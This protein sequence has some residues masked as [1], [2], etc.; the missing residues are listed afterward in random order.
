M[1]NYEY[2]KIYKIT[3]KS[4]NLVYYGSTAL[5]YLSKRLGKHIGQ[6]KCYIKGKGNYCSSF[7]LLKQEDYNIQ[8]IKNFPCNNKT[9]LEKEESHF[10]KNNICVNKA[11]PGRTKQ[12]YAKEY[13][14]NNKSKIKE[15]DKEYYEANKSKIREKQKE[16]REQNEEKIKEWKEQNKEQIKEQTSK[17]YNCACGS[18][19]RWND[20]AKHFK[21]VKHCEFVNMPQH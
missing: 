15:K 21:T 14:E 10:I 2:G 9:Q 13:Y 4:S 20:K 19:V 6:Y 11:I 8:L 1:V 17:P 7:E 5:Y 12:E 16:W 18:V 3:S